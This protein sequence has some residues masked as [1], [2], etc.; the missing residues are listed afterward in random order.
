MQE[1]TRVSAI[2]RILATA[3]VVAM[4]PLF[5]VDATMAF[6]GEEMT[7]SE[8]Q[9]ASSESS[10]DAPE[11]EW[12]TDDNGKKYR[13]EELEKGV[14]GRDW[15]W[16]EED[17]KIKIR[18]GIVLDIVSHDDDKFIYKVYHRPKPK[19]MTPEE[20]QQVL[21][22]K[23][24]AEEELRA[25]IAETY[26]TDLET[27]DRLSFGAFSRGLP[28]RGQWRNG[29]DVADMNA[30]GHLDI[31]FGAP[32]KAYPARPHIYL[33]D[34]AGNWQIWREAR[35][36]SLPFDYGD[37]AVDDF[38][39]DGHMD[40]ALGIHLKG[41]LVMVGNGEG[42]F[43]PWSR[44]IGFEIPGKGGDGST[45][46]SRAIETADWNGDGRPDLLALGEGPKGIAR[47]IAG[48]DELKTANGPIFF[49]NQGDG[50]W[51]TSGLPSK[52]FGESLAM[53][54]FNGDGR[55][56]FVTG[57]NSPNHTILNL[58][59]GGED[60]EPLWFKDARPR[61]Y[62]RSVA[63]GK[64]NDDDVDDLVVGYLS[65]EGGVW[66]SGV[67]VFFASKELE[68]E[69]RTLYTAEDK[70]GIY[71]LATGDL[72]GDRQTDI[73]VTTGDREVLVFLGEED[74][75]FAREDTPELPQEAPGCRGYALRMVDLDNDQRDDLIIGFAGEKIGGVGFSDKD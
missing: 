17:Q 43:T 28:S 40:L 72:D 71:G 75:F 34:S 30:D 68:W 36:P 41:I 27:V 13:L 65:N 15:R 47:V 49:L 32:R 5:M 74:G 64:L 54:D 2:F 55:L 4:T 23:K 44:G 66:R 45:F 70:R 11:H 25:E 16:A 21:D 51:R 46:S 31:V 35:F 52:V 29:F 33:G 22:D 59:Q 7:G 61:A 26:R 50:S 58:G 10:A 1:S 6:S 42:R 3:W 14:E 67:D 62:L 56:D 69:R 9:N 24:R 18:Y 8:G 60:W 39:G 57:S 38:N 12:L 20:R 53:G 19:V 73:V 48:E 63:S 37:A